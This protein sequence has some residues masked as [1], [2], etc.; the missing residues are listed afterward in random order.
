MCGIFTFSV[1][2]DFDTAISPTNND[3]TRGSPE[4]IT[5]DTSAVCSISSDTSSFV[6]I[7]KDGTSFIRQNEKKIII[8]NSEY[9]IDFS[10]KFSYFLL[11][12]QRTPFVG[13]LQKCDV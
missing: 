5:L 11:F 6:T 9:C 4:G 13:K 3:H 1:Q 12:Q 8:I 7:V 10:R 2:I